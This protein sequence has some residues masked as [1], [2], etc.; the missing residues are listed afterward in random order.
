MKGVRLTHVGLVG[1]EGSGEHKC[2]GS[3]EH[4]RRGTCCAKQLA[5]S[6]TLKPCQRTLA[7][8]ASRGVSPWLLPQAAAAFCSRPGYRAE[9]TSHL[10]CGIAGRERSF[11]AT[12][13]LP[14]HL[15]GG[16][17]S[18][19]PPQTAAAFRQLAGL[20]ARAA[21]GREAHEGGSAA[22]EQASSRAGLRA[23]RRG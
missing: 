2:K 16:G 23:M 9:Q 4:G 19:L 15:G 20:L 8:T 6:G 14:R 21:A 13:G 22:G 5:G 7:A 10:L 17:L 1:L 11:E 18:Q 12:P 3:R